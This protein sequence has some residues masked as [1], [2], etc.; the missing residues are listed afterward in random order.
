LHC[1]TNHHYLCI[2]TGAAALG[3]IVI[4]ACLEVDGSSQVYH[5]TNSAIIRG[6]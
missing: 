6:E 3:L 5:T 1:L 4:A 2:Y